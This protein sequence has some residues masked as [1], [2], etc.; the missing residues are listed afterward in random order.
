MLENKG[1]IMDIRIVKTKN[2]IINAFLELRSKKPIEK[3]TVKELCEKA[4]INKST[5]YSHFM[6]IYALSEYLETQVANEIIASLDHPE[7]LFSKPEE[8]NR[9]LFC[10]Y[11]SHESLIQILFSGSRSNLLLIRIENSLKEVIFS[12]RPDYKD[13]AIANIVFTYGIYGGFYA[14]EKCRVFG[15]KTVMEVMGTLNKKLHELLE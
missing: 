8:F 5:F 6:D 13:N 2:S 4:L 10:A 7:Y 11:L 1:N 12:I 3:I 15:D 14:F 9:Q